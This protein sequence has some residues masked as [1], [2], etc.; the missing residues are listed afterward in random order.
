[1][2]FVRSDTKKPVWQVRLNIRKV[3]GYTF[4]STGTEDLD[5]AAY[6]ARNIY[7]DLSRRAEDGLSLKNDTF[8]NWWEKYWVDKVEKTLSVHRWKLHKNIGKR[9]FIPHFGEKELSE[10]KELDFI[11][12]WDFRRNYYLTGP[13]SDKQL[14][15]RHC[16]VV[17]NRCSRRI[18]Q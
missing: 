2:L 15:L 8:K 18:D 14:F 10:I 11:K 9:Y 4:R 1:M 3:K 12:Y 13:G 6:I 17:V 7:E 5:E 16:L